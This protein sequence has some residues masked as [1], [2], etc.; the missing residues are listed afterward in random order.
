MSVRYLGLFS[1]D[2]GAFCVHFYVWFIFFSSFICKTCFS[3]R[4]WLI[5]KEVSANLAGKTYFTV[6]LWT[7][8]ALVFSPS[9]IACFGV[10]WDR[11]LIINILWMQCYRT[12]IMFSLFWNNA[13]RCHVTWCSLSKTSFIVHCLAL[14]KERFGKIR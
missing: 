4:R 8:M 6:I 2:W 10:W 3:R 9:A 7:I 12:K 5:L 14:F 13:E 11:S 1:G